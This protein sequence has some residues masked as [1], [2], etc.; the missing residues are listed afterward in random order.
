[1]GELLG[2]EPEGETRL[3]AHH[4]HRSSAEATFR[5]LAHGDVESQV[6]V[7]MAVGAQSVDVFLETL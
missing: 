5:I 7:D 6:Y 2:Y 3:P 1:M 4:L